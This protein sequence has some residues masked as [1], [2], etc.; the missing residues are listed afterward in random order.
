MESYSGETYISIFVKYVSTQKTLYY[1]FA[2]KQSQ[3][4]H[5]QILLSLLFHSSLSQTIF[6]F[7]QHTACGSFF[8]NKQPT[9]DS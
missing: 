1:Q 3:G 2:Y 4:Q 9:Q 8:H 5:S 7:S 6:N